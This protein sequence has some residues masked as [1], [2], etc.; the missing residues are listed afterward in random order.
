MPWKHISLLACTSGLLSLVG[1]QRPE[2]SFDELWK[3]ENNFWEQFLYPAN[4]KQINATTESVFAEDVRPLP[5]L[6]LT[7]ASW[8]YHHD[9]KP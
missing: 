5:C 6:P 4:V 7:V 1:A 9:L 3:M 8:E 2:F